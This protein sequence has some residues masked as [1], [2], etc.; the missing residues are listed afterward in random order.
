MFNFFEINEI[1]GYYSISGNIET[2]CDERERESFIL[3]T[4][5]IKAIQ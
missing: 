2:T 3:V 4:Q 1:I 5:Q